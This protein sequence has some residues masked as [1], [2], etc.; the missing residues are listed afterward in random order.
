MVDEI[1]K[2]LLHDAIQNAESEIKTKAKP[3][4]K[5][6]PMVTTTQTKKTGD[7]TIKVTEKK[8]FKEPS[9]FKNHPLAKSIDK[10]VDNFIMED[11]FCNDVDFGASCV[12][13][14]DYYI[15]DIPNH[16]LFFL[17][18]SGGMVLLKGLTN[19][20]MIPD[21]LPQMAKPETEKPKDAKYEHF[22]LRNDSK[23]SETKE[24]KKGV[25]K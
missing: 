18:V 6:K 8:Q 22:N 11:G 23:T 7:K 10:I 20:K 4:P 3:K 21:F 24:Y 5:E 19:R 14:L 13:T 9:I 2:K 16:P 25:K 12:L 17:A 1:D 15:A